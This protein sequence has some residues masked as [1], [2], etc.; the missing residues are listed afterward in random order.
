MCNSIFGRWPFLA[1][2]ITD[3]EAFGILFLEGPFPP[4]PIT[5]FEAF[6]ILFS[7]DDPDHQLEP[8][9]YVTDFEVF[10]I[11][12]LDFLEFTRRPINAIFLHL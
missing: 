3:S 6:G 10:V 1:K 11:R 12:F 7:D 4:E 5:T 8:Y 9:I 2:P